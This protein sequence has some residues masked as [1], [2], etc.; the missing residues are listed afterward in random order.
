LLPFAAPFPGTEH[1]ATASAHP[2][3]AP[4]SL[5]P[6]V[7]LSI[8]ALG[9]LGNG[10]AYVLNCGLVHNV[11]ATVTS[12]VTYVIPLFSTVAG[13]VFLGESLN[14]SQPIG[15]LVVIAGVALSQ[16]RLKAIP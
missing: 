2:R 8:V 9:A 5:P 12:T 13:A 14:S 1:T 4:A 15:A 6:K 10:I 3:H 16:G 11:G 7:V